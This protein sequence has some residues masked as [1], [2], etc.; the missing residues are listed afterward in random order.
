MNPD[1]QRVNTVENKRLKHLRIVPGCVAF[2]FTLSV[3]AQLNIPVAIGTPNPVTDEFGATLKG[4][5]SSPTNEC[6]LVQV[7]WATNGIN[8]PDVDGTPNT[9][10]PP[11]AGG[12]SYIGNLTAPDLIDSGLFSVAL[13]DPRPPQNSKIFVRVFNAPTRDAASFYADSQVLTV[14]GNNTLLVDFT[15]T[16]NALDPR[17]ND[18]DGLN[19]SWEKSLG[20]DL[21]NPDSDGDG[22]IDGD[23]FRAGTDLLDEN[24]VFVTVQITAN[25]E[26]HA[27][28]SWD[29]VVGKSYQVELMNGFEADPVCYTNV[30]DVITATG[31]VT[32]T[33]ITN[34]L[35]SGMGKFRVRLVEP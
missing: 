18:S 1:V 27:K 32:E 22:M 21:S 12:I 3:Q 4:S 23:E 24:S 2:L 5:A 30:S 20:G 7:L 19:N 14:N 33:T 34:G 17:D 13:T 9:N 10:N 26:S 29:S 15:A 35:M 8:P 11:V 6:D 25:G 31:T 28:V 16:T